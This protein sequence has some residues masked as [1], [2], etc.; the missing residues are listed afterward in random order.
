MNGPVTLVQWTYGGIL[1]H[2]ATEIEPV[3]RAFRDYL[4]TLG[5][6]SHVRAD[7]EIADDGRSI[8]FRLLEKA[9]TTWA[10]DYDTLGLSEKVRLD[11]PGNSHG[12]ERE[13]L[14]AMLLGPVVFEFPSYGELLAA[15]RI[16]RNIVEAAQRTVLSFHTTDAERPAEYWTYAEERGFTIRPGKSLIAALQQ[17]T[18]PDAG[19]KLYSF[20][21]YRA[22]EYVILLGIAQELETRNPA[23][24]HRLQAQWEHR[25]IM[26]GQFHEVFLREYGSM[27][28]PLPPKYYVP[29]DRLWFRN[30]DEHSSDVGGYEGSWVFYMGGG[31]FTNFWNRDKPYT[32]RSKCLELFHWRNATY[33][34]SAGELAIDEAIVEECVRRSLTDPAE[35]ER[36]L[37][38]M[39]RYREPSGIYRNGGC[40]DTTRECPRWVCPATSDLAL[41]ELSPLSA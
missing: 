24:L 10:P 23:L 27:S 22:T 13:I 3:K 40:I 20:S 1:I 31:M 37:E 25:A 39:L 12:L 30:P 21:C 9:A 5:L 28:E 36:I 11:I 4:G 34:D 17:A 29:G 19:G 2:G 32:L 15:V 18:Q 33:R 14:L 6:E 7:E 38:E 26:S 41:P 35:V 16:Q 8:R